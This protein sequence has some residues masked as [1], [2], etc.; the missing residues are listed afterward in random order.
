MSFPESRAC[1]LEGS[2]APRLPLH[3]KSGE[4]PSTCSASHVEILSL[5]CQRKHPAC[6]PPPALILRRASVFPLRGLPTRCGPGWQQGQAREARGAFNLQLGPVHTPNCPT[7]FLLTTA[8][9]KNTFRGNG[10]LRIHLHALNHKIPKRCIIL[11]RFCCASPIALSCL[12]HSGFRDRSLGWG[13]QIFQLCTLL[14]T[15]LEQW[16]YK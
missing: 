2:Q 13:G 12:L 11:V 14:Q 6:P 10:S 9:L 1:V 5:P 4:E 16:D 3:P 15:C 7:Y 8:Q